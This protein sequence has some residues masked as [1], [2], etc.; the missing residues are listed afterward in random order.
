M[1]TG[2]RFPLHPRISKL[3]NFWSIAPTQIA[4][5][6]WSTIIWLLTLFGRLQ[7]QVFP[8]AVELNYMTPLT[9]S[10][11]GENYCP[12]MKFVED[13]PNKVSDWK[14]KFCFVEGA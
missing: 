13:V 3:L 2:I 8:G 5:N 1:V 6:E 12:Y 4:P 7:A 9:R 10:D 11:V 14:R